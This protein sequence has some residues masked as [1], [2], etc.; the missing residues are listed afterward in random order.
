V[1]SLDALEQSLL[2]AQQ[3]MSAAATVSASDVNDVCELR[4]QCDSHDALMNDLAS[5]DAQLQTIVSQAHALEPSISG[6][7]FLNI[8][9]VVFG[10]SEA[11]CNVM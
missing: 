6:K 2:A 11:L 8:M 7:R 1:A 5:L 4:Q 9:F 3:Q 10:P